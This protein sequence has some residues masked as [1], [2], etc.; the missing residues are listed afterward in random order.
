MDAHPDIAG[1]QAPLRALV[2][3]DEPPLVGLVTRYLE[4][5]G[6]QVRAA[7]DGLQA[8]ELAKTFQ[9][10]VI[11]LDLMLPRMDGIEACR[12]IRTFSDAYVVMLT[13]RTE[14]VDKL[15]GL[16]VGADDYLTKPFSPRE[17][18]ARIRAHAPPPPSRRSSGGRRAGAPHRRAGHRPGRPRSAAC[19]QAG[20]ADPAG[21]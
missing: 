7:G 16:G 17:L 6:F 18:V 19:R 13:A 15:V 10:E 3:D 1:G 21:V 9:P 5:E 8:V 4:R 12:Q 11:V 20:R 2:V 14:E